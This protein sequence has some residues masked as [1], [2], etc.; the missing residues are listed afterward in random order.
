[1]Q[2]KQLWSSSAVIREVNAVRERVVH[3]ALVHGHI[4]FDLY[5]RGE[6]ERLVKVGGINRATLP[7][8]EASLLLSRFQQLCGPLRIPANFLRMLNVRCCM[9]C[10]ELDM[11][12]FMSLPPHGSISQDRQLI[13]LNKRLLSPKTPI[14]RLLTRL[15]AQQA[16][17]NAARQTTPATPAY[18]TTTYPATTY[19]ATTY[20]I[21]ALCMTAPLNSSCLTSMLHMSVGRGWGYTR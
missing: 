8:T 15:Y 11:I 6:H 20:P 12:G 19:P 1:M 13:F 5:N 9:R 3:L 17:E 14:H 4:A 7:Q 16:S 2:R 18:P 21:F 10:G